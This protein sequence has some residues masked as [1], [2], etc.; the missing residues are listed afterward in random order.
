M[1]PADNWLTAYAIVPHGEEIDPLFESLP[2]E[3]ST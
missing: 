2:E 3:E 1:S